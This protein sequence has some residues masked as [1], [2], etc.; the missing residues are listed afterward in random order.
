[1]YIR[2]LNGSLDWANKLDSAR[3]ASSIIRRGGIRKRCRLFYVDSAKTP[4]GAVPAYFSR[5]A[6]QDVSTMRLWNEP[7]TY[8]R[9][10]TCLHPW[11]HLSRND[12]PCVFFIPQT[13]IWGGK[14]QMWIE[15]KISVRFSRGCSVRSASVVRMYSSSPATSLIRRCRP[16]TLS[17]FTMIF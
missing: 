7:S 12:E 1:M 16:R 11:M 9:V 17:V 3:G 6:T 10:D 2:I 4:A 13:G 5:A 8:T 15:R 14:L